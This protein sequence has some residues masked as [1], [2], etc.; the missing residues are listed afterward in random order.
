MPEKT[1][2]NVFDPQ[3]HL[4]K[5]WLIKNRR[6][7]LRTKQTR[8]FSF[9]KQC[10]LGSIKKHKGILG[11]INHKQIKAINDQVLMNLRQ[12][13]AGFLLMVGQLQLLPNRQFYLNLQLAQRGQRNVTLLL[14]ENLNVNGPKLKNRA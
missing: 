13:T 9:K 11:R 10:A 2:K 8:Y 14:N 5:T 3:R 12:G 1:L 7:F 6:K 4:K